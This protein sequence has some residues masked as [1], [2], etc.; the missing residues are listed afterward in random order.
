MSFVQWN[1]EH[2]FMRLSECSAAHTSTPRA[3]R[4][5]GH[6]AGG[7]AGGG[8]VGGCDGHGT[9]QRLRGRARRPR[10]YRRGVG[11]LVG[12]NTERALAQL[13]R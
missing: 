3:R 2:Y 6:I 8:Q 7:I 13:D 9:A 11:V 5:L 4:E 10:R 12:K 1:G